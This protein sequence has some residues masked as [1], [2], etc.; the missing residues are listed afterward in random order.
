MSNVT[1]G[2]AN[3]SLGATLEIKSLLREVADVRVCTVCG[4]REDILDASSGSLVDIVEGYRA[5]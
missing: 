1:A 2:L 4:A 5:N 3:A